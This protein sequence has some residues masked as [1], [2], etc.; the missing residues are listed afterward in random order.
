MVCNLGE[1]M[2]RVKVEVNAENLAEAGGLFSK[3]ITAPVTVCA[4]LGLLLAAL[5]ATSACAPQASN[6]SKTTPAQRPNIVVLFADDMGYGDLS[7]YGHP[8]IRTPEIDE[9][10]RQ[11]QRW[12]DFYV[13]SSVCSPSRGALLTGRLPVRTGIYGNAIRV[14]FP[15]EPWGLPSSE[16]TLAEALQDRGYKTGM[17]GKWHLGDGPNALPTRH[18][19]DEWFGVPYSNDMNWVGE[20]DFEALVK[21]SMSGDVEKQAMYFA[22]RAAKY[23]TPKES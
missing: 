14:Y 12:T 2:A 16:V 9:L 22:R 1:S 8:Y 23:A 15:D 11:G 3:V 18:G 20:P 7:S 5:V 4:K 17:F 19:F 21:L 13:A 6:S 10:A